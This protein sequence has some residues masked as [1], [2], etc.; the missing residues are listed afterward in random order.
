MSRI[1]LN[2]GTSMS[3][4]EFKNKPTENNHP[5]YMG[6]I[7]STTA[8]EYSTGE[9]LIGSVYRKLLLGN[10]G[11]ATVDLDKLP[12]LPSR[13]P[14]SAG[15]ETIWSILLR[16]G[17]IGSPPPK[18][19]HRLQ[20]MPLVPEIARHAC[21][22]GSKRSRW[23]PS[24]LLF[25]TI[26]AG[27]GK[28]QGEDLIQKLGYALQVNQDDDLFARFVESS[29]ESLPSDMPTSPLSSNLF[30][31]DKQVSAYRGRKGET[32]NPAERFCKDLRII[33]SQKE[34]LT[35]RQWTVLVESILR[36]GLSMHLLW[37]CQVNNIVWQWILE[38]AEGNYPP[39]ENEIEHS[40]WQSHREASP[41]LQVGG[42]AMAVVEQHI[43]AHVAARFGINLVLYRLEDKGLPWAMVIG[44]DNMDRLSA[45]KKIRL[46][47]EH[48]HR[49][50]QAI[51]AMPAEWLRVNCA[52]LMEDN[53][54]LVK[55]DS[56]FTKN[57]REFIRHSLGQI[58]ARDPEQASY[59]QAYLIRNRSGTK[60]ETLLNIL[61]QPGPAM[62][63]ALVNA[64]CQDQ[65]RGL[66]SLEDLRMHLADYGLH[67]PLG[68]L[69]EGQAGRDLR[70]LG[71]V[72][73]SPD[74]A[75]GRLLVPPFE[76][77]SR[78]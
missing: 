13:F 45:A 70:K 78:S 19:S 17:G 20:L 76:S 7:F 67:A 5:I 50:R 39:D 25:E 56:G 52:E 30:I 48:I 73:D 15:G 8:P 63:I 61:V 69:A 42:P 66:A 55:L 23:N 11:E 43:R 29:F 31:E 38:I 64:C 47:L 41:L 26:G 18:R 22:L 32:L 72:V 35:R 58:D 71:L 10:L 16:Q 12:S 2:R 54:E 59:D 24:N 68:E 4:N 6:S 75:G 44:F 36:V 27:V 53:S 49:N 60:R 28:Q 33:I 9:I 51:D 3:L 77:I 65:V 74:A 40:L 62:L 37:T 34:M 21:V 46:F 14:E 57:M 1:R